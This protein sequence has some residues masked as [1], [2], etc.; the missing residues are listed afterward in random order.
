MNMLTVVLPLASPTVEWTQTAKLG[1]GSYNLL[2]NMAPLQLS[3]MPAPS[4]TDKAL[5]I[6]RSESFQEIL[7]FGG[8]FTEAA[9]L[10]WRS[11]TAE[12]QAKV[13]HAY[14]APPSEGGHGYTVGRVPI[15]SCDFGP[16]GPER[17]YSFDNVTGDTDL[18]YFDDSVAHDVDIGIIPFIKQAKE[19]VERGGGQLTMFGSPWSPPAWMKLPVAGKHGMTLTA[20]PNGLDPSMQYAWWPSNTRPR[21][22]RA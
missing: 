2:K 13:I 11:L 8:A 14:F 12:D 10:N 18:K 22:P 9:A 19:A 1:D 7:G 17:T 15:N 16:G 6:D 21:H 5:T 4:K 3:S 20:K